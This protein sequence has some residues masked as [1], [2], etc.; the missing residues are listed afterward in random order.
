MTVRASV[1]FTERNHE[2]ARHLVRQGVFNSVSAVVAA[3]L[4]ALRDRDE[5]RALALD[6]MAEEIR[7]R[8]LTPREEFTEFDGDALRRRLDERAAG[9]NQT[10]R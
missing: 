1:S 9:R 4:Q 10:D 7:R 3:G 2:F 5:E 6:A 8:T